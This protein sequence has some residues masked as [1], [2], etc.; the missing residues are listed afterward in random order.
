MI[1]D[2][3]DFVSIEILVDSERNRPDLEDLTR[4]QR[5]GYCLESWTWCLEC[6]CVGGISNVSSRRVHLSRVMITAY[7]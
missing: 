2:Y 6:C 3:L 4:C 1:D 7:A 5:S